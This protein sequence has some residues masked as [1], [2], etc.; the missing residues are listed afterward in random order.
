MVD[1]LSDDVLASQRGD[2]AAFERLVTRF[3]RQVFFTVLRVLSDS[4]LADDVTQEVF[5]KAYRALPGLQDPAI[6]KSWL[7][8]IALNRAIDYRR[9]AGREREQA[10]LFD[11]EPIGMG[12]E[13]PALEGPETAELGVA[14]EQALRTLPPKM[15]KVIALSLDGE[16]DQETAAQILDCPVGTVKSRLFHARRLLREKLKKYLG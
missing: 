7:L 14:L 13:T 8:R 6:F 2:R 4:H 3:Q 15:Q 16:L 1:E 12:A 11:E 9:R 10:F 5:V